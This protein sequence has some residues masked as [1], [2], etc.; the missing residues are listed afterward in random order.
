MNP[1]QRFFHKYFISTIAALTLFLL[2]NLVLVV[3]IR[4]VAGCHAT[5]PDLSVSALSAMVS[6]VNGV[7]E[8]EPE[9]SRVLAENRAWAM[10]LDDGGAVIWEEQM[11]E[12]LPRSYTAAQIAQFSRWYLQEYPVFVWQQP[13]GLFGPWLSQR[14]AYFSQAFC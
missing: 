5:A 13:A 9:V 10:L 8:V 4:V 3:A 11:P 1:V 2:I 14:L 7:I 6:E 12:D